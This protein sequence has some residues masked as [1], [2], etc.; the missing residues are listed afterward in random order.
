MT[1]TNRPFP[2]LAGPFFKKVNGNICSIEEFFYQ[3][4]IPVDLLSLVIAHAI[5]KVWNQ[6]NRYKQYREEILLKS[7][8]CAEKSRTLQEMEYQLS[9]IFTQC[10][11]LRGRRE[12]RSHL[13]L[14]ASTLEFNSEFHGEFAYALLHMLNQHRLTVDT[15]QHQ[16]FVDIAL[17]T[18]LLNFITD[19]ANGSHL[20]WRD[21][22]KYAVDTLLSQRKKK[23]CT[24]IDHAQARENIV[25]HAEE[26]NKPVTLVLWNRNTKRDPSRRLGLNIVK[27][28]V[29]YVE[30]EKERRTL[31]L[32]VLMGWVR[33]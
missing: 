16:L 27:T 2:D 19:K 5:R 9:L 4:E 22:S 23:F 32:V 11:R 31:R 8:Q 25:G 3:E 10:A 12:E 17:T 18:N 6:S 30:K 28:I 13:N 1:E 14:H 29:E 24:A 21:A 33:I 26:L 20:G 15:S 7:G